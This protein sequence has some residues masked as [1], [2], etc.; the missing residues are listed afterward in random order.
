MALRAGV[1]SS[2]P[3]HQIRCSA[4]GKSSPAEDFALLA[5]VFRRRLLAGVGTASL[6]AVGANFGGVTSFL[7]GLFPDFGR[8][9]KLDLLYPVQGFT[10]CLAPN[11]G[12]EFIYPASWVGDQTLLNRVVDKAESQRTLDPPPLSNGRS[13]RGVSEPVVAFGPPGSKGEL[14]VSVIVSPVPRDFSIEDFG[15]PKEVGETVLRRISGTRRGASITATLIDATKREDP[16]KK[17]N[18]YKLEFR[19]EGPSFRRHNVAVCTACSGKLFTLN[20]QAPESTWPKVREE[21]YKIADSF[22][23]T[24]T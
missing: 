18:Y 12:F 15:G 3:T 20:A 9:L 23:L 4:G 16:S 8:G 13:P 1:F 17:V 14:N 11:Y 19:V 7:L 22:S 6:V 5:A 10:R 2:I 21:F 24:E